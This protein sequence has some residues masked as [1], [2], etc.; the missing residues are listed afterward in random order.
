MTSKLSRRYFHLIFSVTMAAG[1]A[2]VM[3]AVITAVNV[4]LPDDFV[5]RWMRAFATAFVVAAPV[6]YVLAPQVR[7][8][9]ARFVE[10][11]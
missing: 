1:M 5:A 6:V 4:G 11:P 9:V 7:R 8:L 10:M 3:T 2:F